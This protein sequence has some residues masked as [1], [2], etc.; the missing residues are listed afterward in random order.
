MGETDIERWRGINKGREIKVCFKY[1]MHVG[2][3]KG[4][5]LHNGDTIKTIIYL[6]FNFTLFYY[7]NV[8]CVEKSEHK[9][10]FPFSTLTI[11]LF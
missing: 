2:R 5:I 1:R 7:F 8:Y 11:V 4:I 6:F 10:Y 9:V 3:H